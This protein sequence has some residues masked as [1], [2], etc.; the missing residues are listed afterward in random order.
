MVARDI[1]ETITGVVGAAPLDFLPMGGGCIADVYTVNF[2]DH[3]SL[4][5]KVG[6][7]GSGLAL[8]GLMLRY[9]GERSR[10]PVPEVIHADDQLLLMSH[11]KTGGGLTEKS[12]IHAAE[13]LAELHSIT[14]EYFGFDCDTVIGGLAQPNPKEKSWP[15]F[16]RDHRLLYMGREALNAGRLPPDV[17][18][19]IEA[20]AENIESWLDNDAKPSLIHG[21][22]WGGNI[23]SGTRGIAGFV[24]PAIYYADAEIELAFSTLFGTFS[25]PFF[26]RYNELR[27]MKPGFFETRRDIYNLYPLLVHVR[28]FGGHY[29]NSVQRTLSQFG[30]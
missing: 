27:P 24:D 20:I 9:L 18:N 2:S 28:L 10:L 16:F 29:V 19:R 8:E 26:R 3:R 11:I 23:L 6:G 17:M 12:Q 1:I 7:K 13:L 25:D 5:A 4:V 22:M 21:D 15:T 14:A 30:F